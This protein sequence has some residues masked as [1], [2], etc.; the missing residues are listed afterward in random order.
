MKTNGLFKIGEMS[1]IFHVSVSSLRHYENIGLLKPEYTD[2]Q[3][4][5]RYYSTRQFEIL[6]TI[7]YLRKLGLPLSEIS[8]FVNNRSLADIR[9][10]LEL[11][12]VQV[13]QQLQE[14]G[15]VE[16][17]IENRLSQLDHSKRQSLGLI[18]EQ[19]L[20]AR[21]LAVLDRKLDPEDD[22]ALQLAIREIEG[23]DSRASVFLGKIGVGITV[24]SLRHRNV[25]P[26]DFVFVVLEENEEHSG[27]VL[28]LPEAWGLSL[29]FIGGHD[30]AAENYK[31]LFAYLDEK[32]LSPDG[33]AL[34]ITMIDQGFTSDTSEFLT[35]I[36]L[37]LKPF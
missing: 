13:R 3:T 34:E 15:A 31:K 12:L 33:P 7:R 9:R 25:R 8:S 18:T 2:E 29:R 24:D 36:Q 5:Y 16:R 26:C 30:K 37:A 6:D 23:L 17:Q 32:G 10:L 27:S 19:Q 35:E 21:K 11:Q 1:K 20:P 22:V 28:N 14:L 4:G